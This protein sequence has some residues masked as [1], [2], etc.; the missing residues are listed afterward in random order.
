MVVF[1]FKK[2]WFFGD[3]VKNGTYKIKKDDEEEN[4]MKK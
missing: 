1:Y 2:E 3:D 4:K